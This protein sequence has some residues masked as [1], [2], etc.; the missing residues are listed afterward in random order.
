MNLHGIASGIISAVNPMVPARVDVSTGYTTASDGNRTPT[1]RTVTGVSAQVQALTYRDLIQVEGLNL[2]G[3][4]RAIYFN[5]RVDGLVRVENKGGDLVTLPTA[6]FVG[7]IAD[8]VLTVASISSGAIQVGD[9]VFGAAADTAIVAQLTGTPGGVG[10]YTVT[11]SQTFAE[12]DLTTGNVWLVA[13]VLEQ[14]PDW[15][16]VAVTLQDGS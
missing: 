3:T 7:S 12:D 15:C 14:W 13:M 11:P 16:K 8:D 9:K 1:Y 6:A 4:R 10:T 2:N 5:G